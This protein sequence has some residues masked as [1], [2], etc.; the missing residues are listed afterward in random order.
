MLPSSLQSTR[1]CTHAAARDARSTAS[2]SEPQAAKRH[3]PLHVHCETI[4]NVC[5]GA[6]GRVGDYSTLTTLRACEFFTFHR[7][8]RFVRCAVRACGENRIMRVW[9][10]GWLT[11]LSCV[12]YGIP[13]IFIENFLG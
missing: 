2:T 8:R 6:H 4:H 12:L 10:V 9:R 3:R 13:Y 11:H 1:R 7:F 5:P